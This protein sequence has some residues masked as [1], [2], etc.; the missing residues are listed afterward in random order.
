[1]NGGPAGESFVDREK[2]NKAA[3]FAPPVY[4]SDGNTIVTGWDSVI[5]RTTIEYNT[6][7]ASSLSA[8]YDT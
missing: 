3:P 4:L 5:I 2:K 7:L 8:P 6:K 1:M